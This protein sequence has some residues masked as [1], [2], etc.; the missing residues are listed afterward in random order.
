IG[1]VV[2]DGVFLDGGDDACGNA[3]HERNHDGHRAKLNCYR[4]L[5]QNEVE[6]RDMNPHR[7]A[8][9]AG[10]YALNPVEILDRNWSIEVI[11]LTNLL[12]HG[13]IALFAGHD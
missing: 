2:P 4:Q 11:L 3:N 6:N 10:E 9:V 8:K 13:R 7:L 12:D 5:L 1:C